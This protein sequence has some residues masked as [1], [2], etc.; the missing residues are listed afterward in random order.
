V[1]REAINCIQRYFRGYIYGRHPMHEKHENARKIHAMARGVAFREDRKRRLKSAGWIQ[2]HGRGMLVRHLVG[3]MKS[4]ALKIQSNWRRFQAQLDVKVILYERLET[5]RMKRAEVLQA[6]LEDKV[7]VIIQRNF[8]RHRDFSKVVFRAAKGE[9]PTSASA[10][11]W[12][13]CSA[14]PPRF[15]TLCILGGVTFLGRSRRCSP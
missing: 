4:G 3:R 14:R 5:L 10:R 2:A 11:C 13:P 15:A 8:R 9:K 7:A 12:L 6:M 1:L